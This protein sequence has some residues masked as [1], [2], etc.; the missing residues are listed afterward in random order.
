MIANKYIIY[1]YVILLLPEL[2]QSIKRWTLY[3]KG[4]QWWTLNTKLFTT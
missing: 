1:Q 4:E 3:W 2:K